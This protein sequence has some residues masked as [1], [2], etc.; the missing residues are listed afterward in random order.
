MAAILSPHRLYG[1]NRKSKIPYL[2]TRDTSPSRVVLE[3]FK[4][5]PSDG[6]PATATWLA[7]SQAL[8]CRRMSSA[9]KIPDCVVANRSDRSGAVAAPSSV[10]Q[11]WLCGLTKEPS[12]FLVNHRKPRELG[13]ASANLHSWLGSHVVPAQP[14]FWGSTKKSSMTS[15]SC[16]CHHAARSWPR[17]PPGP[18]N[19]AYLSSLHLEASPATTFRACSSPAPT[20]VKPQR[21]L[22]ILSE[23]SVHTTLSITHRTRKRRSTR[24]ARTPQEAS[25]DAFSRHPPPTPAPNRAGS[26]R[27]THHQRHYLEQQIIARLSIPILSKTYPSG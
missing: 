15:S 8:R 21:A 19:E 18:S 26:L 22:A 20:P 3:V 16:S 27:A 25:H 10:L 17:W 1:D 4:F 12:G 9:S 5:F 2:T 14:W 24:K 7:S 11:S 6:C 23:E 13:V